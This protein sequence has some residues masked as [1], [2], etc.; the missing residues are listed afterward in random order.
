MVAPVGV[1]DRHPREVITDAIIQFEKY[2]S[3]QAGTAPL[4]GG[5]LAV[6]VLSDASLNLGSQSIELAEFRTHRRRVGLVW[7]LTEP[8]LEVLFGNKSLSRRRQFSS[9]MPQRFEITSNSIA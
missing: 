2:S 4:Y 9:E 7:P 5:I 3:S 8:K 6:N 1:V